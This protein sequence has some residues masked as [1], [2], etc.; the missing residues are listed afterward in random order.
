MSKGQG[1]KDLKR[2]A[3]ELGLIVSD[4][5]V[6]QALERLTSLEL[7]R[8]SWM[9]HGMDLGLEPFGLLPGDPATGAAR[10]LGLS[11]VLGVCVHGEGA[12]RVSLLERMPTGRALLAAVR[13]PG[14]VEDSVLPHLPA[15]RAAW[16]PVVGDTLAQGEALLPKVIQALE[17][18]HPGAGLP[19]FACL[20]ERFVQE[21]ALR[22]AA[23]PVASLA[24]TA[25]LT[26]PPELALSSAAGLPLGPTNSAVPLPGA[27]PPT[28]RPLPM[29]D[30]PFVPVESAHWPPAQDAAE[31]P[32]GGSEPSLESR[33]PPPLTGPPG[34]A[35]EVQT[36]PPGGAQALP[37]VMAGFVVAVLVLV[38]LV[39]VLA[40]GIWVFSV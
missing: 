17:G 28:T 13:L 18:V 12:L 33:E 27:P 6:V 39:V 22:Q 40:L 7:Q 11:W 32:R 2:L 14:A 34:A 21:L 23:D 8:A 20:G 1:A 3:D 15:L 38:A 36:Q 29:P 26:P 30:Q 9:L 25:P 19:S 4:S 24:P 35:R 31:Q 10:V 16:L 5:M 37:M